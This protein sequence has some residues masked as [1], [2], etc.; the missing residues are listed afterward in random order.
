MRHHCR[1]GEDDVPKQWIEFIV[2]PTAGSR[3]LELIRFFFVCDGKYFFSIF[4]SAC[5]E[6]K[7]LIDLD[8]GVGR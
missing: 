6:V 7:A 8:H 1:L 2:V 5:S 3:I 4:T